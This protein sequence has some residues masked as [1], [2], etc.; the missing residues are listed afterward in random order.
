MTK[1]LNRKEKIWKYEPSNL[2]TQE[3]WRTIKNNGGTG[4]E[5]SK[6]KLL[7]NENHA[8]IRGFS[9]EHKTPR[10]LKLGQ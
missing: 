7:F 4:Y 1:T 3:F 6:F 5:A 2:K 8:L 10:Y 9:W